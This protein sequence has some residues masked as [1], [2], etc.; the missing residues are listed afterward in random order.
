[1]GFA[2]GQN[3][4]KTLSTAALNMIAASYVTRIP[5]ETMLR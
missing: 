1:M 2:P 5:S 3:E 4:N